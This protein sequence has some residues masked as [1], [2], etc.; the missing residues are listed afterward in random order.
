[1]TYI[2]S[3]EEFAKA[4]ERLYISD[5]LKVRF[6]MKYRHCSGRLCIK[7]TD[8]QV[9]MPYLGPIFGGMNPGKMIALQGTA[10]PAAQRFSINLQ[11]G[12]NVNPRDDIA[13]HV[14]VRFINSTIVRNALVMQQWGSEELHGPFPVARGQPFEFLILAE[15]H[16]FKI[17]INGLHY[18]EFN[19]RMPMERVS[20]LSIDGEV[21]VTSIR[22]DGG[23]TSYMPTPGPMPRAPPSPHAMHYQTGPAPPPPP[24]YYPTQPGVVPYA[25]AAYVPP[26]VLAVPGPY[27][28]PYGRSPHISPRHSPHISRS[29]AIPIVG[30][31]GAGILAG[32]LLHGHHKHKRHKWMK[33]GFKHKAFK[34]KHK[35]KHGFHMHRWG[36]S[37]SSE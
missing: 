25:G 14:D 32:A 5:P 8:D 2:T 27:S 18:T 36:S 16:A 17:A 7:I 26:T 31:V 21:S 24:G 3:W 22:L 6:V 35:H 1:M 23:N 37:S 34:F 30:G 10:H 20:Y 28:S 29:A 9:A 4:A 13:L 33:S 19:H 11:C 12:P 15:P